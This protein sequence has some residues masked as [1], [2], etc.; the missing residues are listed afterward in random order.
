VDRS[1]SEWLVVANGEGVDT[2]G[3]RVVVGG[4]DLAGVSESGVGSQ[5]LLCGV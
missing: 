1:G 2:G 5:L 4:R 3:P